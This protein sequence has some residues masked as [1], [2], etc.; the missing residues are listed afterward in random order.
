[1]LSII[2]FVMFAFHYYIIIFKVYCVIEMKKGKK[3]IFNNNKLENDLDS[4]F[5]KHKKYFNKSLE[6]YYNINLYKIS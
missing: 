3:C 6:Y 1:M 4:L 2:T 5:I